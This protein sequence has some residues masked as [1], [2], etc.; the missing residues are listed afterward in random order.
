MSKKVTTDSFIRAAIEIHGNKYDYS[1]VVYEKAKIP[2]CIICHEHGEF[3]QAPDKHLHGRGCPRCA[4]PNSSLTQDEFIEKCR[5]RHGSKYNYD[6]TVYVGYSNDVIIT[7]REHGDFTIKACNHLKGHGCQR[8]GGSGRY[9]TEEFVAK[10]KQLFGEKYDYSRTNLEER[11]NNKICV[12]CREHGEFYKTITKHL[13]SGCPKCNQ[14]HRKL[15]TEGFIKKAKTIHGEKFD[16][17]KSVYKDIHTKI[18]VTCQTHGDIFVI[19]NTFLHGY[20]CRKCATEAQAKQL[21]ETAAR[22]FESK[23]R[24][25]HGDKYDYNKVQYLSAKEKVCIVCPKHGEFWQTPNIHLGGSQCPQCTH[26]SWAYTTDEVIKKSRDVHGDRYDYSKT[27]YVNRR[28]NVIIGCPE[29]G[30]IEI[31]PSYHMIGG[32]CPICVASKIETTMERNV[33]YFLERHHIEYQR[34]KQFDWLKRGR[35]MPLDFYLPQYNIGIECQGY[36]H[37]KSHIF[38]G[39]DEG[40]KDVQERDLLKK[41]LCDENG[42][43]LLYYSDLQMDY[44]YEVIG[45]FVSLY[46]AIVGTDELGTNPVQLKLDFDNN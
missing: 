21:K 46:K 15:D 14:F 40:L 17:S 38:F 1:K 31:N 28:T 33:R 36:Q 11:K 30:E 29:H 8:C 16:Y 3:K 23:A 45:D 12:I 25:V 37:F 26:R 22:K 20:G 41:R 27:V 9:T 10:H 7:C 19:P 34:E 39:G 44:P 18:C 35:S 4:R 24:V 42:V 13:N 6:K 2:V 32:V 5:I 43:R